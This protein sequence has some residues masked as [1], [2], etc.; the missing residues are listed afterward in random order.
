MWW[1]YFHDS[2]KV[3]YY[4]SISTTFKNKISLTI[5]PHL[6][7]SST[8]TLYRHQFKLILR[9]FLKKLFPKPYEQ[10]YSCN[11]TSLKLT[12]GYN[13]Y[14]VSSSTS[15]T[16]SGYFLGP[17]VGMYDLIIFSVHDFHYVI[18]KS[19]LKTIN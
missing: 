13:I 1:S 15:L 5:L 16:V 4:L 3:T 19:I 9:Y 8:V 11:S 14:R 10:I 2:L 7:F 12:F 18:C 6:H 17:V